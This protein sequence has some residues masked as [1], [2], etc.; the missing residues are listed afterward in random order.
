VDEVLRVQWQAQTLACGLFSG[1][2][3]PWRVGCSVSVAPQCQS[4]DGQMPGSLPVRAGGCGGGASAEMLLEAA[5][6]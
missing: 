1:R 2:H 3:G 4:C 5:M 6:A